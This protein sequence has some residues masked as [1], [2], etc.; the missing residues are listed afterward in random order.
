MN[1]LATKIVLATTLSFLTGCAAYV[2]PHPVYT[3][4]YAPPFI[5]TPALAPRVYVQPGR[6]WRGHNEHEHEHYERHDD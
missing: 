1:K 4:S 3:R 6:Y 5:V 2:S